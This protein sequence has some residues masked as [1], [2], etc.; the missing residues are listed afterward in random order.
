M[1]PPAVSRVDVTDEAS[2]LLRRLTAEHGPLMFHQ[3]GGC[4]DGP[5]PMCYPD[6]DFIIG[7]ADVHIGDLDVGL[8]RDV[9]VYMSK[10]QFEYWSHTHITIDV[11]K[12]RGI[13]KFAL[14][15]EKDVAPTAAPAA[16]GPAGGGR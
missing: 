5:A 16:G 8:E 2:E 9:P 13:A 15:I 4:C 14:N 11:V 12:G 10:S 6:G 3:S 7:D 1:A